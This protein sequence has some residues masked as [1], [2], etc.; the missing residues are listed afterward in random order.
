MGRVRIICPQSVIAGDLLL[1]IPAYANGGLAGGVIYTYDGT[2]VQPWWS[3]ADSTDGPGGVFWCKQTNTMFFNVPHYAGSLPYTFRVYE[4]P[5]KSSTPVLRGSYTPGFS[6]VQ[7]GAV[8]GVEY[9][10]YLYFGHGN[11]SYD[12]FVARM[13]LSTYECEVVLPI[14]SSTYP[15][16]YGG[17]LQMGLTGAT[18]WAIHGKWFFSS[19]DG[20]NWSVQEWF[21]HYDGS[22]IPYYTGPQL[23]GY[24]VTTLGLGYCTPE[25]SM[26]TVGSGFN[27]VNEQSSWQYSAILVEVTESGPSVIQNLVDADSSAWLDVVKPFLTNGSQTGTAFGLYSY[28]NIGESAHDNQAVIGSPGSL[29]DAEWLGSDTW[30]YPNNGVFCYKGQI[31]MLECRSTDEPA[32]FRR[33][34]ADGSWTVI[35]T[36]GNG[37]S[38]DPTTAIYDGVAHI[39]QFDQ[40]LYCH[41]V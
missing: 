33:R 2:S 13:N 34:E 1:A 9:N 14:P 8:S 3:M 40:G 25:G 29:V 28:D 24:W 31:H 26:Y 36:I 41:E 12:P 39:Q 6:T 15:H 23:D 5:D 19:T 30:G 18:L 7:G 35:A 38:V 16:P 21:Y 27:L 17:Y 11:G 10:G 22:H 32:R 37:G 20:I 4:A